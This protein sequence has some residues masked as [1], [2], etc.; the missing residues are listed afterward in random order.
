V[1]SATSDA[2]IRAASQGHQHELVIP[3]ILELPYYSEMGGLVLEPVVLLVDGSRTHGRVELE[4]RKRY[5]TDYQ[6]I[7]AGS[8]AE[9]L[10]ILGQLRDDRRLVSLVLA[11]QWLPGATGAE[12][13]ARVRQLHPAVRRALLISWGD[14]AP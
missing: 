5:G 13:L 10:G 6:V 4:L 9:A 8:A 12:L 2:D 14:Q 1:T 7:T 3:G 11:D